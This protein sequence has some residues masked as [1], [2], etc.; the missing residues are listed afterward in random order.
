MITYNPPLLPL[1]LNADFYKGN[2]GDKGSV[3]H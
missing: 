3:I 1:F 2:K